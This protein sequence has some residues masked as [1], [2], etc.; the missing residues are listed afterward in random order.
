VRRQP[1]SAGPAPH[2]AEIRQLID[3]HCSMCH[4]RAPTHK[5]IAAPPN[6]AIF[7]SADALRRYAPRIYERA[8]AS[9]NMP[10]GNET[11][12]TADERARLGA[13]INAGAKGG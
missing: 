6:G 3:R 2:Y 13:W 5:G 1:V 11:G 8:V 10:L 9:H 7:D 12:M 4:A